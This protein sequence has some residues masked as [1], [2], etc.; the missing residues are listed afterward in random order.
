MAEIYGVGASLRFLLFLWDGS[1]ALTGK[2]VVLSIRRESD[3]FFWNGND[4]TT[5]GTTYGTVSM[6]EQLTDESSSANVHIEGQYVYD[7]TLIETGTE[8]YT[9]SVKYSESSYLTY[10]KGAFETIRGLTTARRLIAVGC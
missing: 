6:T 7:I 1:I 5:N 9:W 3:K 4:F 2:T 10:F 8:Q